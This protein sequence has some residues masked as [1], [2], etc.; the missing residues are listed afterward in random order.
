MESSL[1]S[2]RLQL[3]GMGT[4]GYS[5]EQYVQVNHLFKSFK[6]PT[7]VTFEIFMRYLVYSCI[8]RGR[9]GD[10]FQSSGIFT[11]L[12]AMFAPSLCSFEI[13]WRGGSICF[14][15][16]CWPVIGNERFPAEIQR[17]F[18]QERQ[19]LTTK[20]GGMT[21]DWCND[22]LPLLLTST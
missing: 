6:P 19:C 2:P 13:C 18:A 21:N 15:C 10:L 4:N 8:V 11:V 14:P 12:C 22:G 9:Q 5:L 3:N 17:S 20:S 7:H 16:W 1:V